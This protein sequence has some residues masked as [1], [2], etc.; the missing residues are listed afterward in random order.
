VVEVIAL[1]TFPQITPHIEL[2]GYRSPAGTAL[3]QLASPTD[4]A[5]DRLVLHLS[6]LR[7]VVAKLNASSQVF[8]LD[9]NES[10]TLIP[11]PN[12]H[13]LILVE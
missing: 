12:G 5:S 6:G 1:Q 4:I 10:A 7:S 2:L 13:L 11:D 8:R 3:R 9:S